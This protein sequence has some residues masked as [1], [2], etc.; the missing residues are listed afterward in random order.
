[1]P[2]QQWTPGIRRI[3]RDER[4]R[5]QYVGS[6]LREKRVDEARDELLAMLQENEKSV[7]THLMLG[8][9]YQN[10][11]MFRE[12]FDHFAYA[13]AVDPMEARAHFLAGS[14]ALRLGDT[15][16]AKTLIKTARDIDPKRVP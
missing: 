8:S 1:M 12:A 11:R 10:R 14:C 3:T 2:G 13:I 6:L 4:E 16:Q 9:L 5:L 7:A 15:A